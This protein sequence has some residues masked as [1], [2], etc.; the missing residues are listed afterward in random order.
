MAASLVPTTGI[1]IDGDGCKHHSDALSESMNKPSVPD[2]IDA[3]HGH[4][5][6]QP[7]GQMQGQEI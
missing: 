3:K 7:L 1:C 6:L 5:S 4:C 2:S